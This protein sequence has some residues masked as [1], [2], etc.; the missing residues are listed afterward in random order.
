MFHEIPSIE[1]KTKALGKTKEIARRPKSAQNTHRSHRRLIMR[2]PPPQPAYLKLLRGNPGQRAVKREPEPASL[3]ELP[4]PPEFL[5]DD[6]KGEWRRIIGELVHLRLVTALDIACFGAYCQSFAY[7]KQAVEALNRAA[8][9]DP[10]RKKLLT[11]SYPWKSA[12][13][14]RSAR[15]ALR[16]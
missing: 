13:A 11:A 14:C 16:L 8:M 12:Q 4:E 2:G 15:R 3:Q 1:K 6:A 9:A 10:E 7:W 5:D